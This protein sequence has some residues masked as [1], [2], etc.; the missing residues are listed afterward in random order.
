MPKHANEATSNDVSRETTTTDDVSRETA[1]PA[2]E[3]QRGDVAPGTD[4]VADP[5]ADAPEPEAVAPG[6]D[7]VTDPPADD[8]APAAGETFDA[9]YVQQLRS[10]S[11]RY[12]Q[13]LRTA[14]QQL[15]G[16]RR[17]L[18]SERV[19]ALGILA[20]PADLPYT[21]EYL[22]AEPDEL[23]DAAEALVRERPHLR[24]RRV[25]GDVGQHAAGSDAAGLSLLG[26]LRAGAQ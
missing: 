21:A 18:H 24:T 6:T 23:R 15:D 10:Q 12:R 13:E 9:A 1:T 19:A 7:A 2:G 8:P 20:D 5:P 25:S 11:G 3:Q 16:L 26:L 4:A 22:D 17:A 14:Q